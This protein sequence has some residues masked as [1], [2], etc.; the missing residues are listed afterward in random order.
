MICRVER[1]YFGYIIVG[2]EMLLSFPNERVGFSAVFAFQLGNSL[3]VA[4]Q[5]IPMPLH[6]F[7][8]KYSS[9]RAQTQMHFGGGSEYPKRFRLDKEA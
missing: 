7:L 1:A 2:T 6:S 4:R 9:E 8:Q 5:D 3:G